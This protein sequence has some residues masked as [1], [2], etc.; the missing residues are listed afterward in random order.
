MKSKIS[1]LRVVFLGPFLFL[2]ICIGMIVKMFAL[3]YDF[4][5]RKSGNSEI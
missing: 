3:F 2:I 4:L 5:G 1:I